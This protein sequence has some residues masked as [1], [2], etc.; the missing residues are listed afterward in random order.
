MLIRSIDRHRC[1]QTD[2]LDPFPGRAARACEIACACTLVT[3]VVMTYDIPSPALSTYLVFFVAKENSGESI[4]TAL[5]FLIAVT[6]ALSAILVLTQ[7]TASAPDIHPLIVAV[8]SFAFF[9]LAAGSKLA[10]LAGTLGLVVADG[11]YKLGSVPLGEGQTRGLLYTLLF[12]GTPLLIFVAYSI[13]FGRHPETL[14]RRAIA[15]RLRTVA[16]ALRNDVDGREENARALAGGNA[17]MLEA[18]KIIGLLH[19]QPKDTQERLKELVSLS[20]VA[21][22]IGAAV[23]RERAPGRRALAARLDACAEAIARMPRLLQATQDEV[24]IGLQTDSGD[25]SIRLAQLCAAMEMIVAGHPIHPYP[26]SKGPKDQILPKK[27]GFFTTDAFTSSGPAVHAFKGASAVMICYLTVVILD[28]SSISTCLVTC[29]IV[30]L[31]SLGE[32]TQKLVLRISGC[33]LGAS[34]GLAVIVFVLPGLTSITALMSVVFLATLP[35]AW[36]A[37]GRPSV[38][39]IGFQAAFAFYLCLLQ[40]A[41]PKFDLTIARDRIIG[42]LYGDIVTYAIFSSIYPVSILARLRTDTVAL[43]ERCRGVLAGLGE[44]RSELTTAEALAEAE[45]LLSKVQTEAEAFGYESLRLRNGRLQGQASRLSLRAL[46]TLVDELGSL[47]AYPAPAP[48]SKEERAARTA[49]ARIGARLGELADRLSGRGGRTLSVEDQSGKLARA[50]LEGLSVGRSAAM[51]S[52]Q[53]QVGRVG[54]TLA[55]YKRLMR[56][57]EGSR[58]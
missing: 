20:F 35:A 31:G 40:G 6:L 13:A 15:V 28:W 47:A 33:C 22:L 53:E 18:L 19:R 7:L 14:L 54:V 26:D 17:S 8:V 5:V 58:A 9:F 12:V 44:G 21:A 23:A 3:L 55:R 27:P 25:P 11:L 29:F 51:L 24:P 56:E 38:S 32:T 30:A 43:V 49:Y 46:R 41:E 42:I 50:D 1:F 10:P 4:V 34:L 48:G 16:L 52:L 45:A 39:Y 37:V 57:G 36:I 2:L